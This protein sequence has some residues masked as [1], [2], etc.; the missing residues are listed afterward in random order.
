MKPNRASIRDA[1]VKSEL[2]EA[3]LIEAV[4]IFNGGRD[5]T[6]DLAVANYMEPNPAYLKEFASHLGISS[7]DIIVSAGS[8]KESPQRRFIEIYPV[9]SKR[10]QVNRVLNRNA[11]A[12]IGPSVVN[13]PC[14]G[15]V[16]T[17]P[18]SKKEGNKGAYGILGTITSKLPTHSEDILGVRAACEDGGGDESFFND[19]M[20]GIES[21]ILAH[22]GS[23]V[24]IT[25]PAY[26]E[27]I[28]TAVKAA[29]KNL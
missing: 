24:D 14:F 3:E 8:P 21:L 7:D 19:Q 15:I 22:A 6:I 27:G 26:V 5:W 2:I 28:K 23:G 11:S 4:D 1:L 29:A 18:R 20:N 25:D 17:L 10:I 12:N 9:L 13:L 16:V